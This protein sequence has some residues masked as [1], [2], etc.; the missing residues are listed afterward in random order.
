[1]PALGGVLKK[2]LKTKKKIWRNPF[3]GS[4]RKSEKIFFELCQPWQVSASPGK[5]PPGLG[6]DWHLDREA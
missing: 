5:S 4:A 2:F 1:L 3:G 6:I